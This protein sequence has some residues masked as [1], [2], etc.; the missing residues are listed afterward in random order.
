MTTWVV[1][2][3]DPRICP[4]TAA[5]RH[6]DRLRG[7]GRARKPSRQHEIV[8]CRTRRR[9]P[10]VAGLRCRDPLARVVQALIEEL[11]E[12]G[13]EERTPLES[14]GNHVRTRAASPPPPF[15]GNP[16]CRLRP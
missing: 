8:L 12:G 1:S 16:S 9:L 11:P 15:A 2:P 14:I 6:V 10:G 13:S 4:A 5:D 3:G 7:P